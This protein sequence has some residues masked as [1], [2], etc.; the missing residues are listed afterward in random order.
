V[1]AFADRRDGPKRAYE[2]AISLIET[3]QSSESVDALIKICGSALAEPSRNVELSLRAAEAFNLLLSFSKSPSIEPGT[4]LSVRKF[5]HRMLSL[6]LT[7]PARAIVICALRGVG[8]GESV[9]LL[10]AEQPLQAPW[11]D[12]IAL[13]TKAIRKRM[14]P[15]QG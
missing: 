9:E 1:I 3:I 15:R 11:A 12:T 13:A 4:E 10:K 8:D 6:Q 5:L 14:K 2:F 7:E